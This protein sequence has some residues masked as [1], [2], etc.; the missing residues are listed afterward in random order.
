M[1]VVSGNGWQRAGDVAQGVS[2]CP[3]CVRPGLAPQHWAWAGVGVFTPQR[4]FVTKINPK[5]SKQEE[6]TLS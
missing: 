1:N 5:K 6:W 4:S 2:V 3:A